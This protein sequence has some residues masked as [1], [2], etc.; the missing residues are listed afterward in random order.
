M[1]LSLLNFAIVDQS[2]FDKSAS[3]SQSTS[4]KNVTIEQGEDDGD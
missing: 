4:D 1:H 2:Y 3:T